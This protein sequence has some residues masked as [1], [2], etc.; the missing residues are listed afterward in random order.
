MVITG[1]MIYGFMEKN[2]KIS[3]GLGFDPADSGCNDGGSPLEGHL[4]CH[5]SAG[6]QPDFRYFCDRIDHRR[7]YLFDTIN[8][9]IKK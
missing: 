9:Q 4:Q 3:D 2:N 8:F 7:D 5:G 6:I 1:G